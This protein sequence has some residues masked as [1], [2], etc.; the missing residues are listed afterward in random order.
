[1]SATRYGVMMLRY[2]RTNIPP[3]PRTCRP[4]GLGGWMA[5]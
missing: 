3:K 5:A 1:M 4:Y 2:A